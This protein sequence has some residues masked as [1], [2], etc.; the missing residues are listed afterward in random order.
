MA[1]GGPQSATDPSTATPTGLGLDGAPEGGPEEAP[2]AA[3]GPT[4]LQV[5]PSLVTGGVERGTVDVAAA[6]AAAGYRSIVASEG[7]PMVRELTRAGAEHI[8]LPLASKKPWVMRKNADRL[9][10]LIG[11]HAVDIVHVRSRA[12]AWSVWWA[13]RRTGTPMV[14]TF[15]GT[16]N[17][18]LP[19]KRRYNSIMTRG[20]RVIAIS[21]FI[22][23][24]MRRIYPEMETA[25][26]R[27]IPR[28]IDLTHYDPEQVSAERV[29]R[30]ADRW[31]LPDGMPIVM[32]PGR[33]TRW[34]GQLLLVRALKELETRPVRCLLVG[35]A[36]GRDG[37]RREIEATA[38]KLGV[39]DMVHVVGGCDDMPA[40]FK[41]ADVVVSASTDPEAFGR[42][43]V[44][45]QAMGRPVVAPRHGG[46]PDQV[47]EG[48]TG[49]LFNPGDPFD[50]AVKVDTA[51]RLSPEARDRLYH[52]GIEN[53]RTQFDKR[54]MCA[55]TLTVYSELL[56]APSAEG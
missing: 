45:G 17:L 8:E 56:G 31:R 21:A 26:I 22:A 25:R 11:A 34:K 13:T 12:P 42:V 28:G 43:A 27:V 7:G 36:Q 47:L 48:E 46:A 4:L 37:Y 23:D 1:E 44:E 35:A 20:D 16:Y 54:R 14:T 19:G 50:L 51:L 33:L 32:L 24:H 39:A 9:V 41:L 5:V 3:G 6:A 30:L 53:A 10:E 18:G 29:I 38:E 55:D 52:K 40:A 15:H 49:W 2:A